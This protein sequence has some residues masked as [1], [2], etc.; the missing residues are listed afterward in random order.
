MF[1]PL[2]PTTTA[3]KDPRP[4]HEFYR[5]DTIQIPFQVVC[6]K[7][8]APLNVTG[9]TFWLTAK[10]AIPNPDAQAAFSGDNIPM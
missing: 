9:W 4:H 8:K 2:I 3:E 6:R 1:P 10:F 7:T 5:G